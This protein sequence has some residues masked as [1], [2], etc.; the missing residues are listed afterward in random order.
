MMIETATKVTVIV[1]GILV[2]GFIGL[3]L[4]TRLIYTHPSETDISPSE[5]AIPQ[6]PSS[7][8]EN[9]QE[10]VRT[11]DSEPSLS[12]WKVKYGEYMQ[13]TE[14]AQELLAWLNNLDAKTAK[15]QSAAGNSA[16]GILP[17]ASQAHSEMD[18]D[19]TYDTF[20]NITKR[21]ILIRKLVTSMDEELERL[22][23]EWKRSVHD[24]KNRA[25][26][27]RLTREMKED[28]LWKE[29]Q[30]L[31]SQLNSLTDSLINEI[32]AV[33]PGAIRTEFRDALKGTVK[34]VS[35]DYDHIRSALGSLPEKY[36]A[37]L[38]EF[39]AEFGVAQFPGSSSALNLKS[40]SSK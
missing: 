18:Y 9:R 17:E 23:D 1:L 4:G 20:I 14:D 21:I 8:T 35:I 3:Q 29:R 24:P 27:E 28:P 37:Y 40:P 11:A 13:E 16:Q 15:T 34:R 38:A 7:R 10:P 22:V 6:D 33:A 32:K 25:E 12:E 19:E 36:D 2:A 26:E 30:E 31:N 5:T 39:F